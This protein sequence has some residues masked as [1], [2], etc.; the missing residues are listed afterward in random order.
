MAAKI[1]TMKLL[2]EIRGYAEIGYRR[3][4]PTPLG[5]LMAQ[6]RPHILRA[7]VPRP[8]RFLRIE[9]RESQELA[10]KINHLPERSVPPST[11]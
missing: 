3:P 6:L 5:A 2:Q 10:V 1:D 9:M 4:P 7:A 8:R 11:A